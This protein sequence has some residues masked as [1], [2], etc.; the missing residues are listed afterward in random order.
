MLPVE[1]IFQ[2]ISKLLHASKVRVATPLDRRQ[3]GSLARHTETNNE[4][5]NPLKSELHVSNFDSESTNALKNDH[6]SL[7]AR[8]A[9]LASVT[10][11]FEGH[12]FVDDSSI[13]RQY[14]SEFRAHTFVDESSIDQ[15][16]RDGIKYVGENTDMDDQVE[17][18]PSK[19]DYVGELQYSEAST[20]N[21]LYT[22]AN[23]GCSPPFISLPYAVNQTYSTAPN[24]SSGDRA[25]AGNTSLPTPQGTALQWP[26][27]QRQSYA[28]QQDQSQ[29]GYFI[30]TSGRPS[31]K[32]FLSQRS[33]QKQLT[34]F[35][36]FEPLLQRPES[37]TASAY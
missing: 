29:Q 18:L 1:S 5:V 31:R 36:E 20:N 14:L 24:Y 8:A 15:Q 16:F 21:F 37:P 13:D 34:G 2:D 33:P 32:Y 7:S 4:G 6:G 26:P 27:D 17:A 25:Y 3:P 9:A 28:Y 30:T 12:T 10:S 23:Q 22:P 19:A 11:P 35:K